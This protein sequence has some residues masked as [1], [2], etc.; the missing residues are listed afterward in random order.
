MF[1]VS[2]NFIHFHG[3]S[4]NP[5]CKCIAIFNLF[6]SDRLRDIPS[7]WLLSI[8]PKLLVLWIMFSYMCFETHICAFLLGHFL[9]IRMLGHKGCVCILLSAESISFSCFISSSKLVPLDQVY[10]ITVLVSPELF[11]CH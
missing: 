4:D 9:G 10:D 6:I 7:F 11:L 8:I 2:H 5:L 1:S 3:T